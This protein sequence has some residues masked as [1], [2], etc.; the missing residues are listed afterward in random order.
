MAGIKRKSVAPTQPEIKSK[1]KKVKVE[2]SSSKPSTKHEVAHRPKSSK[3]PKTKDDSDDLIESDSSEDED[4]F[5]GFAADKG[6]AVSTSED[7][8]MDMDAK[9][10]STE[11]SEPKRE[12]RV[13]KPSQEEYKTSALAALNANSSREAHAK[14][15]T[16]AKERKAA[17]PNADI[18]ER[19]KK[20]W[21]KLRLK[22]HTEKEERNKLVVE[23]FEIVTGRVKDFVFKHDSVRVV[24]CAVKYSNMEQ[25]RMIAREL[26]GEFKTLAEGKYSKFLI[27]KLLEKGDPEILE[28]IITEFYGHVRRMIN[29]PEAAWILD[30]SYRQVMTPAQKTRILREWYGPEFSIPGLKTE[31]S[32]TA[33]LLSI[34]EESPEKR[35][36]IME[37]L[38]T[39]INQLIQKKLTGFTMLHDAMLQYFLACKPG[40]NEAS[41]FLE[42]LKP[43]TTLKEGEEP[44]NVDLLKNLAF[45]KP[46]SRLVSLALAHGTAKDRKLLLRPYK[47]TV[48]LMAFDANAHH[49]LLA[50]MAVVDDTKLT[51]KSIFGELLPNNDTLPEKVLDLTN[52]VRARTVL[53]YPFASDSKWLLDDNTRDRLSELYAIRTTTSKK[54]PT[55]RLQE[56]AR[57]IEGQ[58][59][60]AI[61]SRAADFAAF[62]FGLQFLGEVLVGA[63]EVEQ[64]KRQEALTEVAKLSRQILDSSLPTSSPDDKAA[65][66]GKNMLKTLVQGGKFDAQTRKVV[67]VEPAL[68]FADMF[69]DHI[70]SDVLQWA[71]GAGS[72]VIVGLLEAENFERK[73]EVLKAL[74]KERKQLEAAAGPP[75]PERSK[76]QHKKQKKG[77][78]N[79][80]DEKV[81]DRPKRN[82]GARLLLEKL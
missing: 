74:K 47:D 31:K 33:E 15:K 38:E 65:S 81:E 23:L 17:K 77:K 37:H 24:Q 64:Q 46:G 14:Q 55:T 48:H 79:A 35:K 41:D 2:K 26:K 28:L 27:A 53:L 62:S 21:E 51:S 32:T 80:K 49:V 25:R 66:H 57:P 8:D 40:T 16:L 34:L 30:D 72:F 6:A 67:P 63:P 11:D 69:W 3:K 56:I 39:Q 50:A 58:L 20:L 61:I 44:D 75:M 73:N 60:T 10:D 78:Q 54:D 59:L 5:H 76:E 82:A 7:E 45:T 1:S 13:K 22:S 52:D 19:S 4:G 36:P 9:A 12:K 29:H 71:T 70:K 68:G 43:D 42:H 18:I